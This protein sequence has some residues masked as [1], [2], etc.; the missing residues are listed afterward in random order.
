MHDDLA[1]H[2]GL[3]SWAELRASPSD[4]TFIVVGVLR[5]NR[6]GAP[7]ITAEDP[8]HIGVLRA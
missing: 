3:P 7:Y 5:E 1:T 8:L 6:N 2:N 4:H